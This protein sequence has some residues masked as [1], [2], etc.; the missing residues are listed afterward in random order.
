MSDLQNIAEMRGAG[1]D[2]TLGRLKSILTDGLYPASVLMQRGMD[3]SRS[4]DPEPM[5]RLEG[6]SW[7]SGRSD[8]SL[9][10][11]LYDN[12]DISVIKVMMEK[13]GQSDLPQRGFYLADEVKKR[14]VSNVLV[15]V[16]ITRDFRP[17]NFVQYDHVSPDRI[18]KIY[19][20]KRIYQVVGSIVNRMFGGQIAQVPYT[21]IDFP[22]RSRVDTLE[23]PDYYSAVLKDFGNPRRDVWLTGVRMPVDL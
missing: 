5:T 14:A 17:K 4:A 23:V 10:G 13:P 20:P 18:E 12:S 22:L 9:W 8:S 3:H 6:V 7:V 21:T 2:S 15:A 11:D 16:P 19:I 1:A